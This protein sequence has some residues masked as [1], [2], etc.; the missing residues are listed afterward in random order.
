[1]AYYSSGTSSPSNFNYENYLQK[2]G[3]EYVCLLAGSVRDQNDKIASEI[4]ISQP[5]KI[6]MH[7][8]VLKKDRLKL[9][10][11]FHFHTADGTY[12]FV[13][14]TQERNILE[15]GEYIAEC[16][17]PGNFLNDQT[18]FID[19]AISS[20]ESGLQVHFWEKS[21]L[22][23]TVKDDLK[24][25]NGYLGHIPGVFRPALKWNLHRKA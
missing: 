20:L 23:F 4:D 18:Y 2:P 6:V 22:C 7:F 1:M 3:D 19:F 17:I 9:A 21:I 11:N 24:N 16:L 15:K 13:S 25:R 5:I 14:G 10:P 12:A 8:G